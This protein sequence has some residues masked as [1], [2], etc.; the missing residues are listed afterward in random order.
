MLGIT[1]FK[2]GK[3]TI[4][5]EWQHVQRLQFSVGKE[6]PHWTSGTYWWNGLTL[7][8]RRVRYSHPKKSSK[9]RMR[10]FGS[11]GLTIP[12]GFL[13]IY[14][15]EPLRYTDISIATLS[16]GR[17]ILLFFFSVLL[18][19][20][21]PWLLLFILSVSLK[22]TFP[23]SLPCYAARQVQ[24][25]ES[26]PQVS[27]YGATAWAHH[28]LEPLNLLC[29]C[30]PR[31]ARMCSW[32]V[33]ISDIRRTQT[34]SAQSLK[35]KQ[36]DMHTK[37]IT[38][39]LGVVCPPSKFHVKSSGPFFSLLI[40]SPLLSLS[41]LIFQSNDVWVN[42]RL[43]SRSWIRSC[44]TRTS[45]FLD[46][47]VEQTGAK[48]THSFSSA[49]LHGRFLEECG[50]H[51]EAGLARTGVNV[52]NPEFLPNLEEMLAKQGAV[53]TGVKSGLGKGEETMK[54]RQ[55]LSKM[56]GVQVVFNQSNPVEFG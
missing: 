39:T 27:S 4:W 11:L 45:T 13:W 14:D 46:S 10:N 42:C 26:W 6:L 51:W 36:T 52:G 34:W 24:G 15:M 53:E 48:R 54:W 29:P 22:S 23:P 47:K 56:G 9:K 43:Y 50:D 19:P 33:E 3:C 16:L 32:D 30:L 17:S 7:Q 38:Q 5:T 35:E 44:K 55:I 8:A 40:D 41:S 1:S 37:V 25:W 21:V 12:T 49:L 18:S 2:A 31:R 20:S 28:M